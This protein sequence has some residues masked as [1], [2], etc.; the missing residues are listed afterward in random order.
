MADRVQL[1]TY[2]PPDLAE[3]VKAAAEL[4]ERS[5]AAWI[6]VMLARELAQPD[7]VA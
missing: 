6:R 1:Q 3:R 4:D 7:D 2:V 5:V